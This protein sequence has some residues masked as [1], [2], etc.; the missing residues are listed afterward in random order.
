MDKRQKLIKQ[1]TA[2]LQQIKTIGDLKAAEEE[3]YSITERLFQSSIATFSTFVEKMDH[4]PEEE[5]H[6]K[7][8]MFQDENFLLP[9][10]L[11]AEMER[12]DNI[13]GDKAFIEAF[14]AELEKRIDPYIDQFGPLSEKLMNKLMSG[15]MGDAFSEMFEGLEDEAGEMSK[16]ME[17]AAADILGNLDNE[18][19]KDFVFDYDN[20]ATPRMMYELYAARN[21]EDMDIEVLIEDIEEQLQT[22]IVELEGLSDETYSGPT[23]DDLDS[24]DEM[25]TRM[26]VFESELDKE[27]A[28]LGDLPGNAEAAAALK[29]EILSKVSQKVKEIKYYLAKL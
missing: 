12:M 9:P 7:A 2:R 29:K 5:L 27:L 6:K 11:M 22:D 28:R 10:E 23:E 16:A 18:V 4:I 15:S 8:L 19:E 26:E 24:I 25:R 21:W 17:E 14:S 1:T 3:I 20:P 13:R